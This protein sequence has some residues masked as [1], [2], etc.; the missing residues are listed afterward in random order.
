[1]E[2]MTIGT[3]IHADVK[4]TD[5]DFVNVETVLDQGYVRLV[6]HMGSDISICNAARISFNKETSFQSDGTLAD[7]DYNLLR[8]LIKNNEMSVYR[9]ATL[10]FEIYMPLMIAR[11]FWKYIVGVANVN[12]GVCMNES[13]RRY[14]TETPIFYIPNAEQWRGMPENKKQGSDQPI[15]PRIGQVATEELMKYVDEGVKLYE[16]WQTM[17][18]ATEQARLFL[19][20]YGMYIRMR[21]TMSL[22][23]FIHFLEERLGNRAQH[24]IYEYARA[25]KLLI[26]PLFPATFDALSAERQLR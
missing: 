15:D 25:M 22:A 12:D 8:F 16:K 13:S 19:P 26:E 10:Q 18:I 21:T 17:G 2:N 4:M 5:Y 11:Q 24:E 23:S 7:K 6:D 9:H 1:M 14:V 20:S 3:P